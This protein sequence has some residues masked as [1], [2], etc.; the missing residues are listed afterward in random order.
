MDAQQQAIYKPNAKG[1]GR[2]QERRKQTYDA[3]YEANKKREQEKARERMAARR[4]ANPEAWR[5]FIYE[6][7]EQNKERHLTQK[8]KWEEQQRRKN[9]AQPAC[10]RFRYDAHVKT[11]Y[12]HQKL[13]NALHDGHV[14]NWK[15]DKGRIRKWRSNHDPKYVINIR[16][17]VAIRKALDGLKAGRRWESIVG[18]S[19]HQLHDHLQRQLPRGYTMRDFF[20]GRLH[21]DH[22]I[23]K[24]SFDV[25]N[26][27]ELRACWALPNLRPLPAAENLAKHTKRTHLL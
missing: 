22:I 11:F 3:W 27:A 9:G 17:R 8:R 18:Y 4:T 7:R 12:A 24:S 20:N 6:W 26:E 16:M 25:V 1:Q 14:L 5:S 21:I 10:T 2:N 19:A 13:K 15:S 23:P